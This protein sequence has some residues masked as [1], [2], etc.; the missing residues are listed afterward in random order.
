M[1][2]HSNL[3]IKTSAADCFF[4]RVFVFDLLAV[5]FRCPAVLLLGSIPI[6]FC[7]MLTSSP[8]LKPEACGAYLVTPLDTTSVTLFPRL[9]KPEDCAPDS[10]APDS[11][12][13]FLCTNREWLCMFKFIQYT[14][15]HI[16]FHDKSQKGQKPGR[17]H[18]QYLFQCPLSPSR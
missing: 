4:K 12:I 3:H 16:V 14:H 1:G 5:P 6:P 15:R 7:C 8:W 9:L 18:S 13:F 17:Y 10:G 2:M 11:V